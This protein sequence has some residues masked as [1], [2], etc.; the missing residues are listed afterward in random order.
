MHTINVMHVKCNYKL[1][2]EYIDVLAKLLLWHFIKVKFPPLH[3]IKSK[4][5][6][7]AVHRSKILIVSFHKKK[8]IASSCCYLDLRAFFLARD[9]LSLGDFLLWPA[10]LDGRELVAALKDFVPLSASS[11]IFSEG[12]QTELEVKIK[13]YQFIKLSMTK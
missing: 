9:F 4:I 11:K 6:I 8:H 5:S 1:E 3:F 10:E 7:V 12:N 2:E 13:I